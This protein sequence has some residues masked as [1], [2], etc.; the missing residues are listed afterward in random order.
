MGS[1][2]LRSTVTAVVYVLM[3][4]GV[5][6]AFFWV[7]QVGAGLTAPAP[8][9]SGPAFGAAGAGGARGGGAAA[10]DALP[11]VLLALVVILIGGLQ[12]LVGPIVGAAAYFGVKTEIMRYLGDSWQLVLGL[13]IILLAVLFPQ[14]IAG[15]IKQRAER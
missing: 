6:L 3:L 10:A 14:G 4:V 8:P 7:R 5:V 2:R 11:H 12:T 1:A 9:L 13:T 15:F